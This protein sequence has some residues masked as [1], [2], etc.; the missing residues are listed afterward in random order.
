MNL[1]F[2]GLEIKRILRDYSSMFFI[3][4]LPAFFYLIFGAA[5]DYSQ[6]DA[7]N[8][9]V[10]MY[11]MISM[12]GYGAATATT[13]IGGRAAVER[14]QG[15]ARQLGLTPLRDSGYVATK[16]ALAVIIGLV[17]VALTFLLGALTGARGDLRVWAISGLALAVGAVM[18]ALYGLCAGLAFRSEAA[19]GAASGVLVI[20]AFLGNIFIP[21]SGTMLTIAKFTPLYGYISLARYS[22]TDGVD[23]G[24]DGT[25][26]QVD[27]WIPIANVTVWTAIFATTAILLVR[28][29]R[30]RP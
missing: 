8:G 10:A 7:G 30:G 18:W 9:N 17:P 1:T 12:A 13:G 28:R 20:L 29:G 2:L 15:W 23:V 6:E 19:V 4:L 14:L 25:L 16:T 3:V 26:R 22:L 24:S 11:I 27:L 21:L 5:Q